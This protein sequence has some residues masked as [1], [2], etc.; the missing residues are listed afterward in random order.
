M[1][2]VIFHN[3]DHFMQMSWITLVIS[4]EHNK[5]KSTLSLMLHN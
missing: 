3:A 4:E 1:I 2:L 5:L